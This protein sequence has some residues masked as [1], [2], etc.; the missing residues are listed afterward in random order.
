MKRKLLNAGALGLFFVLGNT[1][2]QAQVKDSTKTRAIDEVV[3]VAYGKQ[4]AK[5]VVGS[6]SSVGKEVLS[7]QQTTNVATAIQG[8]VPGVNIISSADPGASPTIRVRGIGSINASSDPLIIVD[9][10]QYT[11]SLS[12][13]S[14]EEIESISVLKDG[15]ATSL[16]GSRGANGVVLIT[17]KKGRKGRPRVT[18]QTSLGFASPV[19]ELHPLVDNTKYLQYTWEA[20]RNTYVF[21]DKLSYADA[22]A[23][24]ASLVIP[25]L[26]YNPY[27][28]KNPIDA[29]GN[30]TSGAQLLWNTDWASHLINRSAERQES[31][32]TVS[33]GTEQSTYFL[34]LNYL[35]QENSVKNSNFERIATRLNLESKVQP[36]L[37]VGLNTSFVSNSRNTP[38]LDGL[39]Y[40]SPISSI[41]VISS[42]YPLYQR[43]ENGNLIYDENGNLSYDYGAGSPS[44][45]NSQRPFTR[46]ANPVG[47]LVYNNYRYVTN[48]LTLNGF[49]KID[50]TKDLSFR[51]NYSFEQNQRNNKSYTN[52]LYGEYAS[53]NGLIEYN[54]ANFSTRN[55][56]NSLNYNTRLGEGHSLSADAIAEL[57]ETTYDFMYASGTGLFPGIKVLGGAN[58][59]NGIDGNILQQRLVGLLGRVNYNYK[60]KY[61]IEG[62]FRRDGS[63]VFSRDTRWGNFFSVGGAYVVSEENF[64]KGNKTLSFLKL[65]SSYGELGNNDFSVTEY[66]IFPYL[67]SYSTGYSIGDELGILL[68]SPKDAN[69]TWEKTASFN[70]GIELGLFQNRVNINVDYYDKHSVDLIGPLVTAGST[71]A[72]SITSNIGKLKNYGWEFAINTKNIRTENFRWDTGLNFSFDRNKIL[73]LSND[74]KPQLKDTKRWEV[75][76][77]LFEFYM[78]EYAGV[79]PDNGNP[80]WYKDVTD[81]NGNITKV[82]TEKYSD[83]S[84]Y[85]L[86]KS[87]IPW[88]IGGFNNYFKYKNFDLNALINFSFGGYL[89]DSS[90]ARLMSG[91]FNGTSKSV[92]LERRWQKPG[93]I[94]DVPR[95]SY[96]SLEENSLSSRFLFKNDYV[97]L[98][99]LNIGYNFD[100]QEIEKIGLKSLRLF[101]QADNLFT[102][103]T[104]KNTDPEQ[105]LSGITFYRASNLKTISFGLKLEL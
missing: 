31:T 43:D 28:V 27:N 34:S 51:S 63:S 44:S 86:N 50:F 77:S 41:Y 68:S 95:L 90:Y 37:S 83:A 62:S 21:R 49:A 66:N 1:A 78:R 82:T 8:S 9:G 64:L 7:T 32:A 102:W 93:D 94:T 91:N 42:I 98:K 40:G 99:A 26:Q 30:L 71:G 53:Q 97:R 15:S 84:L 96:N 45:L 20:L 73:A 55:F 3:I 100:K 104:H 88:V 79:N 38:P 58:T 72:T 22:G 67:A 89:Y 81:A 48:T 74:D 4:K 76:K 5:A 23:K 25:T 52:S 101:L 33:G 18:L 61:F 13:I 6:V 24:A 105:A 39:R 11:G 59:P 75:G 47:S 14:Q 70:A 2:S 36:W 16:Y 56:I 85:Y 60:E 54:R 12:N 92:D 29:N 46:N 87:S 10:A 35:K 69:I 57:F 17:T 19:N 103:Q 65:K 80:L